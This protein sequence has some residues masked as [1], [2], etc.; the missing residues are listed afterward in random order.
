MEP[1][2]TVTEE[3]LTFQGEFKK[4]FNLDQKNVN[5][6]V[7][8]SAIPSA[9]ID[10]KTWFFVCLVS[11]LVLCV[12]I[13]SFHIINLEDKYATLSHQAAKKNSRPRM[14][15]GEGEGEVSSN[16]VRFIDVSRRQN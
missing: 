2:E 16:T 1:V 6:A 15:E 11:C 3:P 10:Y 4:F 8:E 9:E 5:G 13:C 7:T 12:L 14:D